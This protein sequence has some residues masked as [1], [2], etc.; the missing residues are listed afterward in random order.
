MSKEKQIKGIE[1]EKFNLAVFVFFSQT[2]III[3]CIFYSKCAELPIKTNYVTNKKFIPYILTFTNA[4]KK[5]TYDL[6]LHF[7]IINI[8]AY[9][10]VVANN[11]CTNHNFTRV[12][13]FKYFL[14]QFN[15]FLQLDNFYIFIYFLFPIYKRTLL[16]RF[17]KKQKKKHLFT[18]LF[19]KSKD[20]SCY[21]L[22]R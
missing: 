16:L 15:S 19:C 18:P 10:I 22:T 13:F 11:L 12:V 1:K 2:K 7:I 20:L 4:R 21:E 6:S 5:N 9:L 8:M 17:W 14:I 3:L